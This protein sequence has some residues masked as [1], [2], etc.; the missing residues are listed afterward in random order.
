MQAASASVA[1]T[2]LRLER[3]SMDAA[4][5]AILGR[6]REVMSGFRGACGGGASYMHERLQ[7][8]LCPYLSW[9]EQCPMSARA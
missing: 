4:A 6:A 1:A 2:M 5:A 9:Q 8:G 7:Q 3:R